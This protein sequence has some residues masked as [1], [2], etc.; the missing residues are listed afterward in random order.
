MHFHSQETNQRSHNSP[1]W[2][3]ASQEHPQQ[4]SKCFMVQP[5][6]Q[7]FTTCDMMG[8]SISI[9]KEP[10]F[11]LF[12]FWKSCESY[13]SSKI[14]E[15][16]TYKTYSKCPAKTA[17]RRFSSFALAFSYCLTMLNQCPF[18]T[19]IL[20]KLNMVRKLTLPLGQA[21]KWPG[22]QEISTFTQGS[23]MLIGYHWIV[24]PTEKIR[25][26]GI[27]S[28]GK[29]HPVFFPIP[30]WLKKQKHRSHR[31]LPGPC[32]LAKLGQKS[33]AQ[34][35]KLR[36]ERNPKDMSRMFQ[37]NLGTFPKKREFRQDNSVKPG[38][39]KVGTVFFFCFDH[40]FGTNMIQ[41][42]RSAWRR[43]RVANVPVTWYPMA[44]ARSWEVKFRQKIIKILQVLHHKT[45]KN[46]NQMFFF[47]FFL[48]VIV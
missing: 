45:H 20:L 31:G 18:F 2:A 24:L 30:K 22:M 47:F 21:K 4:V 6:A 29:E 42:P 34:W 43:N 7:C 41:C 23:D 46:T 17:K 9:K 36:K 26:N 1:N 8:S 37:Q 10:V 38:V 35:E 33:K 3:A 28:T 48:Y 13:C 32:P 12:Y 39:K 15:I 5:R 14:L 27:Q 16:N 11:I 25:K 19:C 40:C 44:K